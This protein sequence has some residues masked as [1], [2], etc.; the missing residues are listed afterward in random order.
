M[1]V[2]ELRDLL[3]YTDVDKLIDK[4]Q[5]VFSKGTMIINK[6]IPV[7]DFIRLRDSLRVKKKIK[8]IVVDADADY[9][10]RELG[11]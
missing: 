10:G 7:N 11:L 9:I 4:Y 2:E 3:E 5:V 6:K 8:N 1:S